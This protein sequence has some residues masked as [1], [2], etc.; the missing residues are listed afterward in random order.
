MVAGAGERPVGSRLFPC[1]GGRSV[2][3]LL[4]DETER[5]GV[6]GCRGLAS[7]PR[8]SEAFAA[9]EEA[10]GLLLRVASHC[11]TRAAAPGRVPRPGGVGQD[12]Q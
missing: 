6:L 4:R 8:G 1:G 3:S 12:A 11:C 10:K 9:P 7:G 5:S 2:K